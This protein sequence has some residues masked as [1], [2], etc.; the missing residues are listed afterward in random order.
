MV[1]LLLALGLICW[2][3]AST[4]ARYAVEGGPDAGAARVVTVAMALVGLVF[5]YAAW[6]VIRRR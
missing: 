2:G 3:L 6:W 5:F 4:A 1:S